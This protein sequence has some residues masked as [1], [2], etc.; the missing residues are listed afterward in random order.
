MFSTRNML[1]LLGLVV[2]GAVGGAAGGVLYVYMV[3]PVGVEPAT[4]ELT[5]RAIIGVLS[6]VPAVLI[7]YMAFRA[8]RRF[9]ERDGTSSKEH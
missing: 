9:A 1:L 5:R 8:G 2:V 7:C 4:S 3:T 6:S